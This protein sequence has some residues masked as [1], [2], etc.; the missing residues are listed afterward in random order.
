[1]K[2]KGFRLPGVQKSRG[3]TSRAATRDTATHGKSNSAA[4]ASALDVFARAS[5]EV[6]EDAAE[7]TARAGRGRAG[8]GFDRRGVNRALVA[9]SRQHVA[10]DVRVTTERALAQD[11]SIFDYD[12]AFD[13]IQAQRQRES[14]SCTLSGGNTNSGSVNSTSSGGAPTLRKKSRYIGTLLEKAKTRE[15]EDARVFER[16][17]LRER[18]AEDAKFGDKE[19]FVTSAYKRKLQEQQQWEIEDARQAEREARE[20][21][22]KKSGMQGFYANML[23][24]NIAMGSDVSASA[25]SAYTPGSGRAVDGSTTANEH[26]MATATAPATQGH[27]SSSAAVPAASALACSAEEPAIG[28]EAWKAQR[29]EQIVRTAQQEQ[30]KQRL[31]TEAAEQKQRADA[32]AVAAKRA[33]AVSSARERYLERKRKRQQQRQ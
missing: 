15:R 21:V 18:A 6:E 33:V 26:D 4:G 20:D 12:G 11:P 13:D 8:G 22:T 27:L 19:R 17:L 24:R 25:T 23:T 9:T 10:S 3:V 16:K 30:A 14:D 29:R 28:T 7:G 5:Q 32:E 2:I 31:E 1:M